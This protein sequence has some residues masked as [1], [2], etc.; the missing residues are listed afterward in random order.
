[1]GPVKHI[2]S[3]GAAHT[4]PQDRHLGGSSAHNGAQR[5]QVWALPE[6]MSRCGAEGGQRRWLE[7]GQDSCAD[8][9]LTVWTWC[10]MG[11]LREA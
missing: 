10:Q 7:K 2:P 9:K 8:S 3:T 11:G 6:G 5:L 4:F 1:M